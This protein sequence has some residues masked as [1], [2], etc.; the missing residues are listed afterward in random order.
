MKTTYRI[1]WQGG[2]RLTDATFRA[3]DAYFLSQLIPLYALLAQNGYGLLSEAGLRYEVSTN[4]LSILEL[5]CTAVTASGRLIRLQF[6]RSK[7]ELFQS[8]PMPV[9]LAPFILYLD[10]SSDETVPI[11][12]E[13]IPFCDTDYKIVFREESELYHNP[14][15]IPLARFKFD[16]CWTAD[17]TFIPPCLCLK[18]HS[19]LLRLAVHYIQ[20]LK[21]LIEQLKL[22]TATE[23]QITVKA[24]LPTVYKALVEIE[25]EKDT[26]A[27][28]HFITLIQ[29][30]L[31][32]IVGLCEVDVPYEIPEKEAFYEYLHLNYHPCRIAETVKEGIRLTQ[33][34]M[35]LVDLFVYKPIEVASPQ[36][37][38]P[39]EKVAH[40]FPRDLDS[41]RRS[42]KK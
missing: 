36:V 11:E 31:Q 30:N 16:M 15:A 4:E 10:A 7:R 37:E 32:A 28:R 12:G 38:I 40:T 19:E 6:D 20:V 18:A 23:Q 9:S 1:N 17:S 21:A 26:M 35:K 41:K 34:L 25:K 29:A 2:M 14:D 13:E 5:D 24:L 42:F 33:L 39:K 8:L 22:K 27:P 3:S